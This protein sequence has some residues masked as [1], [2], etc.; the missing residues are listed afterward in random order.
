MLKA[1]GLPGWFWWEVVVTTVYLLNRVPCK[2]LDGGITPFEVWYGR[3]PAI[4]HLKFFGCIVY[5]RNTKPNLKKMK[6]EEDI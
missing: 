6:T 4:H 2:V 5:V 1:K 3:K